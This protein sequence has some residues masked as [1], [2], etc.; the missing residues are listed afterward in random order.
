MT[1]PLSA[2]TTPQRRHSPVATLR[3]KFLLLAA[4]LGALSWL[5]VIYA[6]HI[7]GQYLSYDPTD[8]FSPVVFYL[9]TTGI[10]GPVI[11]LIVFRITRAYPSYWRS[12]SFAFIGGF[13]GCLIIRGFVTSMFPEMIFRM[14]LQPF[15][16]TCVAAAFLA[17]FFASRQHRVNSPN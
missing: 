10:G 15:W 6:A 9:R 7:A 13:T 2:P 12:T 3:V 8:P 16:Q 1:T 17:A 5:L 4:L 11:F 14:L